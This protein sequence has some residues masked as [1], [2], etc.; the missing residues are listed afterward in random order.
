MGTQSK[1]KVEEVMHFL[2]E[3]QKKRLDIHKN[4]K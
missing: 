2:L 3:Q 1:R 4:L